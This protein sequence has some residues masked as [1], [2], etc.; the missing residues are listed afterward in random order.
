MKKNKQL[1]DNYI[2]EMDKQYE[3][4]KY[5]QNKFINGI[6]EDDSELEYFNYK[7]SVEFVR[8]WDIIKEMNP[9]QRNIYLLFMIAEGKYKDLVKLMDNRFKN[10]ATLR[11]M[12]CNAKR[13]IKDRY[14]ELYGT[15]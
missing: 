13:I 9:I 4:H 15:D 14:K 10:E 11:V 2:E 1:L 3:M 6:N 12:V 8:T 5:L 7:K